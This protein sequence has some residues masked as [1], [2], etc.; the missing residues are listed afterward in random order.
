MC[1][2][3]WNVQPVD[4]VVFPTDTCLMVL[5]VALWFNDVLR[6]ELLPAIIICYNFLCLDRLD[7]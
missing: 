2:Q 3:E 6:T 4:T 1:L 7:F 5:V